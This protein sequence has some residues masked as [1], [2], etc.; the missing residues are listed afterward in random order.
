MKIFFEI[1]HPADSKAEIFM[2]ELEDCYNMS[3]EA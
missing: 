2:L 3:K 1:M